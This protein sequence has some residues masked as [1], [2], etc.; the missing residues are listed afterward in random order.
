MPRLSADFIALVITMI[1]LYKPYS[2]FLNTAVHIYFALYIFRATFCLF[3]D[4]ILIKI[5][6]G[7]QQL[8]SPPLDLHIILIIDY[9]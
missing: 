9:I 1:E 3:L 6:M 7:F 8:K 4:K 5:T 2:V